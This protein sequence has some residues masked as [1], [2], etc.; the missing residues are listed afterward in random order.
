MKSLSFL[1]FFV[2]LLVS[3]SAAAEP[4][5]GI[6]ELSNGDQIHGTITNLNDDLIIIEHPALGTLEV[7]REQVVAILTT[8]KEPMPD[9]LLPLEPAD[10]GLFGTGLMTDW[11]RNFEF[12]LNGAKGVSDNLN[13]RAAYVSS[14]EDD[15]DRW[16]YQ[17]M[18]L[19]SQANKKTSQSRA[20]V[21]LNKDWL[22]P[23]SNWFYFANG[24][25]DWDE[26]KDWTY[27]ISG[28]V[29]PGYEFH[30][31]EIWYLRTRAGVGGNQT[32][33]G[34]ERLT[35]EAL[36]GLETGWHVTDKQFIEFKTTFYPSLSNLGEYRNIT[37]LDWNHQLDY[38][39]GLAVK[40]GIYNEYDSQQTQGNDF[41]YYASI[42]WGL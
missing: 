42:V 4:V 35:L 34:A 28:F 19:N 31:D 10:E 2:M 1:T 37:T 17:M 29:G 8:Q 12:G 39:R 32:F 26:F 24:R 3:G 16:Y 6:I 9:K 22:V 15:E 25:F 13:L 30:N 20:Q 11:T 14:Y 23:E 7:K 18:Y 41:R 36:A 21:I 38:Y 33:G 40:L 27:R 5:D